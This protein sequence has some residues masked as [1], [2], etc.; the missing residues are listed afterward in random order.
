MYGLLTHMVLAFPSGRLETRAERAIVAGAYV[1]TT[2]LQVLPL[3]FTDTATSDECEGCPS[4]P[5][6]IHDNASLGDALSQAQGVISVL[7]I[8]GL[9]VAVFRRWR[10]LASSQRGALAPVLWAGGATLAAVGLSL[11][12]NV[13]GAPR[14]CAGRGLP[15]DPRALRGH[16]VRVPGRPAA[17]P[18][19]RA[20]AR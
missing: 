2:V 3:L 7:L 4:N 13:A 17:E 14:R 9:V 16:P 8:A 19:L 10:S 20:P 5:L 12:L 6:L 15:R 18:P 11:S 1:D